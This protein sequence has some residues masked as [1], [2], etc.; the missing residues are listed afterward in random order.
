M[1]S[2]FRLYLTDE[3]SVY[4]TNTPSDFVTHLDNPIELEGAWKAALESITYSSHVKTRPATIQ[5]FSIAADEEALWKKEPF[6]YRLD[7]D[8]CWIGFTGVQPPPLEKPLNKIETVLEC[9]NSMNDHILQNGDKRKVHGNVFRFSLH[10]VTGRVM[11]QCFD[12]NFTI[13][14]RTR[15]SEFLGFSYCTIF[16]GDGTW[17]AKKPHAGDG[18]RG[19]DTG[20][21]LLTYFNSKVQRRERRIMIKSKGRAVKSISEFLA[22]W[23]HTVQPY[24]N[25]SASIKNHRLVI[26]PDKLH[27]FFTCSPD[28]R[29]TFDYWPTF[30]ARQQWAKGW[31]NLGRD[32]TNDEWY[33]D[34]YSNRMAFPDDV[35]QTRTKLKLYPWQCKTLSEAVRRINHEVNIH[36]K[37]VMKDDYNERQHLFQLE[38]PSQTR[39]THTHF[40]LRRK[41]FIHLTLGQR[42]DILMGEKLRTLFGFSHPHVTNNY[43]MGVEKV[44]RYFIAEEDLSLTCSLFNNGNKLCRFPHERSDADFITTRL[45]TPYYYNVPNLISSI[46]CVLKDSHH[47]PIQ[48]HE[49]P[50]V[51]SLIFQ[52]Q[53]EEDA[54]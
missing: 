19:L 16:A 8:E 7:E 3:S 32:N 31:Y 36:L 53:R 39:F 35:K 15:T 14:L 11:Y 50:T 9:L 34:V 22:L 2:S 17:T 51:I 41:D 1:S 37:N 23:R 18:P 5:M 49:R 44:G 52:K 28:F 6:V 30:L 26:I 46:R 21:F 12:P 38:I 10:D 47:Q 25:M 13:R 24:T 4:P 29:K 48:L 20:A 27:L 54:E 42:L 40:P 43:T 45:K 33:I